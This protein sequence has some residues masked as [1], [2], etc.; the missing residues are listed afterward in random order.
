MIFCGF[1]WKSQCPRNGH[2]NHPAQATNKN[3]TQKSQLRQRTPYQSSS[4]HFWLPE[5]IFVSAGRPRTA[6]I[7]GATA[8]WW[9][10]DQFSQR[11][12]KSPF[13]EWGGFFCVEGRGDRGRV[14]PSEGA[15][16]CARGRG[17]W[18][19][20]ETGPRRKW[21]EI[22]G[23]DRKW[24]ENSKLIKNHVKRGAAHI[25]LNILNECFH[26]RSSTL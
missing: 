25:W 2:R 16:V 21:A 15:L 1:P 12:Q 11:S 22:S 20:S 10:R 26:G 9:L 3:H 23:N 19:L 24:H 14:W 6:E 13:F 4:P 17:A 5:A 18:K 7:S 8:H